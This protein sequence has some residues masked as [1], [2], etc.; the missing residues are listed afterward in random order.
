MFRHDGATIGIAVFH[1]LYEVVSQTATAF[2][3]GDAD[4]TIGDFLK[5]FDAFAGYDVHDPTF[6]PKSMLSWLADY[7]VDFSTIKQESHTAPQC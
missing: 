5:R 2:P 4:K 3:Y 7:Q 6:N 1:G